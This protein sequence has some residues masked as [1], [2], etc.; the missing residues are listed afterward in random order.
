VLSVD[1]GRGVVTRVLATDQQASHMVVLS[2]DRRHAFVA[3]IGSDSVSVFDLTTGVQR[4]QVPAGKG[5][6]AIDVTPDG[7]EVWVGNRADDTLTIIDAE[8]LE[9]RA[10]LPCAKFPIRLKI[11]PDGRYALVSCAQSG[12]IA[13]FDVESRAEVRRVAMELSASEQSADYF[14]G[15]ELGDGPLPIGILIHPSGERAWIANTNADIVTEL[16]LRTWTITARI[17]T[18]RQ[19]DGLGLSLD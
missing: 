2:P 10:T 13:V 17:P 7:R 4:A 18:G 5:P 19:P 9:V 15:K 3:N 12:D 1:V 14:L 8:G 11:T 6:E 16:D